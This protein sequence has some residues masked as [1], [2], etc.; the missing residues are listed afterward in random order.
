VGFV[1]DHY[2]SQVAKPPYEVQRRFVQSLC[3][4]GLLAGTSE[5]HRFTPA[6]IPVG[7]P[8]EQ[9]VEDRV[10]LVGDAGGFVNGFSAEGIYYAMVS[11]ELA[12]KA[13]L[14]QA[15]ARFDR[16]WRTEIGAELRDSVRVQR[17][18]FCNPSRI[19][20]MVRGA[21]RHPGL[22][23]NVIDYAMGRM[24]YRSARMR[25]VAKCPLVAL[26]MLWNNGG[27]QPSNA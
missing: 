2:R 27:P 8:L 25:L 19:N 26:R 15:P 21:R 16:M 22:A 13:I 12:A 6:L 9:I 14:Q 23:K 20:A 5:R 1:L 11:G 4:S 3:G 10:M 7:G 24:S 18:L 17:F